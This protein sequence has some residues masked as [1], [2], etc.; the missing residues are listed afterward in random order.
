MAERSVRDIIGSVEAAAGNDPSELARLLAEEALARLESA[1]ALA[2]VAMERLEPLT[3]GR[4]FG[5]GRAWAWV[6]GARCRLT[7]GQLQKAASEARLAATAFLSQGDKRGAMRALQALGMAYRRSGLPDPALDALASAL[8]L[9]QSLRWDALAAAI[10]METG[11]THLGRRDW[12]EAARC[13]RSALASSFLDANGR[14]V[15]MAGLA[16]ALAESGSP[17][18]AVTLT[19]EALSAGVERNLPAAQALAL[20]ARAVAESRTGQPEAAIATRREA[21]GLASAAGDWSLAA[22]Q[23]VALGAALLA[24]GRGEEAREILREAARL[25]GKAGDGM[26]SSEALGGLSEAEA[27]LG[28]RDEA[29]EVSRA[30]A[31]AMRT[32]LEERLSAQSAAGRAEREAY[33]ESSEREELSRLEIVSALGQAMTD[34]VDPE[35]IGRTLHERVSALVPADVFGLA[36]YDP[37]AGILDFR[38]FMEDAQR[39]EPFLLPADSEDSLA[40]LCARTGRTVAINDMETEL[41]L[42][43]K[44]ARTAG[45]ATGD[46]IKSLVYH[47][48]SAG[49]SVRGLLSVQS[50]TPGA[51]GPRQLELVKA[52]AAYAGVALEHSRLKAEAG[53]TA[54]TDALTGILG[55]RRFMETFALEMQRVRRY[56]GRLGIIVADLDRFRLVNDRWGRQAGDLLLTETASR[57]RTQ[58][59]A[60]DSLARTDGQRFMAILP[61][62]GL[63]GTVTAA[64]RL[65]ASLSGRPAVL[66]DGERVPFSASF[67]CATLCEGDDLDSLTARADKALYRA[68]DG[69]RDRVEAEALRGVGEGVNTGRESTDPGAKETS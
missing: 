36:L 21:I 28:R 41:R 64:D 27:S 53:V 8:A 25:A 14:P 13:M 34:A 1:P 55:K 6:L 56:C 2:R 20:R 50:R 4:G 57:C 26:L 33:A 47:P 44:R 45:T 61:C 42:Y 62:T 66:P 40:G 24:A 65:R 58:L 7:E 30:S 59:R 18:E 35:S 16:E 67:G 19:G 12:D 3:D 11:L 32:A 37:A 69:G 31:R 68:K 51:Y 10:Q 49:G 54:G 43:V 29:L 17:E 52:M 63:D 23:G 60:S 38:Y 48:V 15:A 46:S 5:T 9:A 39:V 22:G